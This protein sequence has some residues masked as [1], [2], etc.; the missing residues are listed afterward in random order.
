MTSPGATSTLIAGLVAGVLAPSLASAQ[1]S[2]QASA[3][4]SAH[5][6]SAPAALRRLSQPLPHLAQRLARHQPITIVAIGSSSTFGAGASS[7]AAS[8][9]SRLAVEL[10]VRF[11]NDAIT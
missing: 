7:Q 8:Y 9:P 2:A 10:K 6:C 5:A 3:Q 1:V 4:A 11:P